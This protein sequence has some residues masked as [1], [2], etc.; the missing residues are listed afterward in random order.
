MILLLENISSAMGDR[1]VKSDDS[2]KILY[3]D[4][5]NLYWWAMSQYSPF[6]EEKFVKQSLKEILNT[7]DDTEVGYFLEVD[8]K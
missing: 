3:I 2:K 8:L 6:D 7:P 1:Y 4:A 5:N